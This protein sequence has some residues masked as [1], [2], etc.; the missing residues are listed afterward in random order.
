MRLPSPRQLMLAV[1]VLG[2]VWANLNGAPSSLRFAALALIAVLMMLP[3][4]SK[5]AR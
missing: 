2:E 5:K 1:S 3:E 4:P